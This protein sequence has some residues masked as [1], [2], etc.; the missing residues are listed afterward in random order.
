MCRQDKQRR[1]GTNTPAGSYERP[2]S[3]GKHMNG[4]EKRKPRSGASLS[5]ASPTEGSWGHPAQPVQQDSLR[6]LDAAKVSCSGSEVESAT[7]TVVSIAAD[8]TAS[9]NGALHQAGSGSDTGVPT[10]NGNVE[11][12]TASS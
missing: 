6:T 8:T 5:G 3:F 7:A 1:S 10:A 12:S 2:H 11:R 4:F 9:G